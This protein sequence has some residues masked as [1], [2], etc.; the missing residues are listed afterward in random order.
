MLHNTLPLGCLP[1]HYSATQQYD[2]LLI[3]CTTITAHK[4][5]WNGKGSEHLIITLYFKQAEII[6]VSR[7]LNV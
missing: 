1:Q 4:I 6:L 2:G 7:E 5:K 3:T